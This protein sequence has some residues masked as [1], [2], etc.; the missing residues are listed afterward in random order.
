MSIYGVCDFCERPSFLLMMPA[1]RWWPRS[2]ACAECLEHDVGEP[3]EEDSRC[4]FCN[5][6][7][8]PPTIGA[9]K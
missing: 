4:E 2:Y 1:T 7:I 5:M 8:P 9:K 6:T 3:D